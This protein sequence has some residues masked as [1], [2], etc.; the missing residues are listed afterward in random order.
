MIKIR[1]G[2]FETNSSMT[3]SMVL[4]NDEQYKAWEEGE[5]YADFW[6]NKFYT[7]KQV[8]REMIGKYG[9]DLRDYSDMESFDKQVANDMEAI[10]LREYTD[11]IADWYE[12]YDEEY[13][14]DGTSVH[15][16]GYYGHD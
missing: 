16:V 10:S 11:R 4:M 9:H 12:T 3:H 6:R 13:V 14:I 15:A 2:V 7:R 5:L 8:E 1:K